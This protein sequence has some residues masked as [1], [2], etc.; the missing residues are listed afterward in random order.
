[1]GPGCPRCDEMARLHRV[2]GVCVVDNGFTCTGVDARPRQVPA[3][4]CVVSTC[5]FLMARFT[6]LSLTTQA[7]TAARRS[8]SAQARGGHVQV[9]CAALAEPHPAQ[10]ALS[11]AVASQPSA[12]SNCLR[13]H[14]VALARRAPQ[15]RPREAFGGVCML[16]TVGCGGQSDRD[17][18]TCNRSLSMLR[19]AKFADL[20]WMPCASIGWQAQAYC[21][22]DHGAACIH[23]LQ[24][25]AA[26]SNAKVPAN[27]SF[28]TLTAPCP[29]RTGAGFHC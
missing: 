19:C 20:T 16:C 1:M 21:I 24:S 25:I 26:A 13:G 29:K 4:S 28:Q 11:R 12:Q 10:A 14:C 7:H 9:R 17:K 27:A 3:R 22:T 18:F 6:G 23:K 2:N 8:T 5:T 15:A